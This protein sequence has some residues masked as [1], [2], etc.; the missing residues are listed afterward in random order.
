MPTIMINGKKHTP[1][2]NTLKKM[3]RK[4]AMEAA[5]KAGKPAADKPKAKKA[6]AKME[7]PTPRPRSER[8]SK[9][10]NPGDAREYS[11]FDK[12]STSSAPVPRPRSER[13]SGKSGK[14]TKLKGKVADL[15]SRKK[16]ITKGGRT[17][18]MTKGGAAKS[19]QYIKMRKQLG[20][21]K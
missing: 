12:S 1:G 3:K 2:S 9:S 13:P 21:G 10:R 20:T 4:A 11:S 18:D 19:A 16:P 5:A 7:A 14:V 6:K 8:P 15:P 17:G